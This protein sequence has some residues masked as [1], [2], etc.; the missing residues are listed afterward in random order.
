MDS[1]YSYD[2]NAETWPVFA[3]SVLAAGL[4]PFT[5]LEGYKLFN[6]KAKQEA[7]GEIK[8]DGKIDPKIK[9]FRSRRKRSK[10]FTKRNL[11]LALGWIA[12]AFIIYHI[13]NTEVKKETV[14]FDPYELLGIDFGASEKEVK[15]HYKK[16][17]IKFHPDKVRGASDEEKKELEERFVLITKAYKALTDEVTRENFEKYGHPDG[18]QQASYGIALP[19]FL[20]EGKSSPL[21]L[22]LYIVLI[23]GVLPY[24]VSNWWSKTKTYTKKGIHTETANLFVEKLLNHKPTNVVRVSTITDWL[25]EAEEFKIDFPKKSKDEIKQLFEDHFNRKISDDQLKAVSHIPVL[26]TGLVEIASHFRN[27]EVSDMSVETLKHFI[28]A[29]PESSKNE[30]LQLPHVDRASVEKSKII[31]LGKL[32]TLKND[33]IKEV[34]GIKD[35]DK[36]K[37]ALDVATKIPYLKLVKAEYKVPGESVVTPDSTV[38]ISIKVVVKSPKHH[39]T[40][41]VNDTKLEEEESLETLRD[42]FKM[43]LSQPELPKSYAPFFP[44][45]RR[46]GYVAFVV[47]QKDSKITDAPSFFKNLDLSNLEL[48]EDQFKDGSKIQV[49]TFKIPIPQPTPTETGKYEFRVILKSTDYFTQ[50]VDFPVVMHVQDPPKVE[51]VNYDIPDPDEDSIAGALAQLKGEKVNKIDDSDDDDEDESDLEDEEEDFTDINTDTE[52]EGEN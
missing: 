31:R 22:V 4:V 41:R 40:V 38:H 20:I 37:E 49:G 29:V 2:E 44:L 34:L 24:I 32:L 33:E 27:T 28:Q 17:S 23:G 1:R 50:D 51:E 21:L 30:L 19:K 3:L 8:Y 11:F 7:A 5:V 18:P 45:E 48:T 43:V 42:P 14:A 6:S 47:L 25:S 39:G 26:I 46:G 52:D 36:L 16:I 35:D 10:I 9:S 15:S 13:K 12:V